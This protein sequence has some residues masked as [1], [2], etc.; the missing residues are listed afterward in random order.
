LLVLAVAQ[1]MVV[2][3]DTVV[4]IALP[5][6]QA[7]FGFADG[8]RQ[9]VVTGYAAAFAAMLPPGGRL[10]DRFGARRLLVAGVLVF[11]A[12]SVVGG[13][14][15]SL[16]V[17]VVARVVQGIGAGILAPAALA[18][19]SLA[20]PSGGAR[21]RAFAV[22]SATSACG[23]VIG[24]LLG[25]ALT[26]WSWRWSLLINAVI[27]LPVLVGAR[28]LPLHRPRSKE[29]VDA[30]SAG[31]ALGGL[32]LL[33]TGLSQLQWALAPV[34]ETL[35][36]LALVWVFLLRQRAAA[37]P[38]LPLQLLGGTRG[39]ALIA[40]LLGYCGM[41]AV[42]VFLT[43][44]LQRSFGF[45][46]LVTGLA[47]LPM[48][49]AIGTAAGVAAGLG[50]RIAA[51]VLIPAGMVTAAGGLG[52]LALMQPGQ[53]YPDAVLG[54]TVVLGLGLGTVFSTAVRIATAG[55]GEA[56]SG[57]AAA[58]VNI[59]QQVGVAVGTALLSGIATAAAATAHAGP[60]TG[61]DA[62]FASGA[63]TFL[64]GAALSGIL[65]ARADVRSPLS[66]DGDAR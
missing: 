57:T 24:L 64:L 48:T 5:R 56:A 29:R 1:L 38:L 28:V 45:S 49:A 63:G 60:Y 51:G 15:P 22:F 6:A 7:Q 54:P 9:W 35:L 32:L 4:N 11:A 18:G 40:L 25:G 59:A 65:L 52:W 8:D 36:G 20:Y 37:H 50:R 14:A 10:V 19:L 33:I 2:L 13:V 41:F 17:R 21:R 16:V 34:A 53:G 66:A 42:F 61:P 27:A 3:D 30:V 39:A 58:L 31:L 46:P 55:A 43:Y 62:A 23:A 44:I 12:G 26:G 47:Y